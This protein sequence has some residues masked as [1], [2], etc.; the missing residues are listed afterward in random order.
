VRRH[1][2]IEIVVDTDV[3]AFNGPGKLR[4]VVARHRPT[5]QEVRWRPAAAFVFIGLDPNSHF[6]EGTVT[7]DARGFVVTD[8]S[9]STSLSG[10]FAA[11]D[12]RAGST[13]QLGA[14]VGEGIAALL[15][16]RAYLRERRLLAAPGI[17]DDVSESTP[18]ATANSQPAAV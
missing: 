12:V 17:V 9:F 18:A 6:L 7:R 13:K 14:A 10:L 1:P 11:G 3:V 4:E 5:G 8:A 2:R 16:I 15:Q